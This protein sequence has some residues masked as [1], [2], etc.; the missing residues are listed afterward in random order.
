M[1]GEKKDI[2]FDI[3]LLLSP[4]ILNIAAPGNNLEQLQKTFLNRLEDFTFHLTEQSLHSLVN[5]EHQMLMVAIWI[6]MFL[7][8]YFQQCCMS[9]HLLDLNFSIKQLFDFSFSSEIIKYIHGAL[10]WKWLY[11][12]TNVKFL[13]F[14][15]LVFLKNWNNAKNPIPTDFGNVWNTE[16]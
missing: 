5:Q 3:K 13:I 14:K 8:Q 9:F 2:S 10:S 16:T 11:P 6:F 12:L 15:V 7:I 1:I 4:L